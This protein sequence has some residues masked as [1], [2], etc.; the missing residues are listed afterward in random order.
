MNKQ[1]FRC[2]AVFIAASLLAVGSAAVAETERIVLLDPSL[3]LTDDWEHTSFGVPTNYFTQTLDGRTAIQAKGQNSASGLSRDVRFDVRDYSVL[4]WN[5]RVDVLP[6]GADIRSPQSD[7][8]AAS[9]TLIF[10][11]PSLFGPEPL[12]L[13]Y[14]WT[15]SATPEG[16]IVVSPHHDG[17]MRVIVVRSG[18]KGSSI[19]MREQRD[20]LEDFLLAFGEDPPSFVEVFAI[21]SDSDQTQ[22]VV[23]AYYG[24]AFVRHK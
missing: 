23:N 22:D 12:A 6:R 3:G 7:D 5:W 18:E 8:Y 2:C 19:W 10:G 15:S 13:M 14:A 24:D 9:V 17:S 4:E 20:I 11:R 21:W 16:S 1:R